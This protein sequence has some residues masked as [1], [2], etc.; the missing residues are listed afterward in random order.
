MSLPRGEI[1]L[2]ITVILM[3]LLI[4]SNYVVTENQ[5]TTSKLTINKLQVQLNEYENNMNLKY[6]TLNNR[7]KILENNNKVNKMTLIQLNNSTKLNTKRI[8]D[9]KNATDVTSLAI[10]RL[11]NHTTNA[12]L[13]DDINK[14]RKHINTKLDTSIDYVDYSISNM[15]HNLTQQMYSTKIE[16]DHSI[17]RVNHIA[18]DAEQQLMVM[19]DKVT[20]QVY[21]VSHALNDTLNNVDV[22]VAT[23]S[24]EINKE[25]ENIQSDISA[26]VAFADKQFAAENDFVKYQLAGTFTLIACL[27]S[28][29]HMT[30]HQKHFVKP[31][32]QRRIMAILWMVP[33]YSLTSWLS[34]VFGPSGEVFFNAIRDIYEAYVVYTF[35]GLLIAVLEEGKGLS[36]LIERV[37]LH[38][39]DEQR[40][41]VQAQRLG[42]PIPIEHIKPPF[43]CCY[44]Y[45][46]PI[47]IAITWLYQCK[48]MVMQF[49]LLK[50]LLTIMPVI[51]LLFGV[52]YYHIDVLLEA[53][54]DLTLFQ[55][56]NFS[57]PQLYLLMI[58]NI[59]VTLAFYGLL[60]FYHGTEK[61]LA[62]CEPWPKFVCVKS[63]VFMTFW[64][65]I[66]ISAMSSLGMV[67]ERAA[68][69]IQNLLICIEMLV[70]SLAHVYVF[71][72]KEWEEG[73][74]K[75]KQI[76]LRD[77]LAFRDFMKDVKQMV[78]RWSTGEGLGGS[79]GGGRGSYEGSEASSP[80]KRRQSSIGTF[81]MNMADVDGNVDRRTTGSGNGGGGIAMQYR[82]PSRLS[83]QNTHNLEE[84]NV[85]SSGMGM[86]RETEETPLL[87]S[88]NNNTNNNG[89][90]SVSNNGSLSASPFVSFLQDN[91]HPNSHSNSL[92]HS[93]DGSNNN[94]NSNSDDG[95]HQEL[96]S[97][98][99]LNYQEFETLIQHTKMGQQQQRTSMGVDR[100]MNRGVDGDS[101][102][103]MDRGESYDQDFELDLSGSDGGNDSGGSGSSGGS[104][105]SGVRDNTS[106][107][108]SHTNTGNDTDTD[109]W[110]TRHSIIRHESREPVVVPVR[111]VSEISPVP[112]GNNS[113]NSD[114]SIND[115][116][117]SLELDTNTITISNGNSNNSG[118]S[119]GNSSNNTKKGDD[120]VPFVI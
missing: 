91:S 90:G 39:E 80:I 28:M 16:M 25:V 108:Y 3:V 19:Q 69:Q 21:N 36:H 117:S 14:L 113:H 75:D 106:N 64:Q 27:I 40:S 112:I 10:I 96:G 1:A 77:T 70:A 44:D 52:D 49:V 120:Q 119:T 6:I 23:A 84:G 87:R 45:H 67:N 102:R 63:I 116:D 51:F 71:P 60:S 20:Q 82:N 11:N 107:T 42:K 99:G 41:V 56:I 32:V 18:T 37:T 114:M 105:S 4:F 2:I 7:I 74:K 50:P 48:L 54:D 72:Y 100:G 81:T 35:F 57:S 33:V 26:Y 98:S 58:E 61:E 55:R 94:T 118:N 38:V 104:R 111:G 79:G 103:D 47:R 30:Q 66:C 62:W 29:Y 92:M 89:S 68:G 43:P 9:I 34:L 46:I 93:V 13:K 8:F 73:Y 110:S 76:M 17:D 115:L 31:N 53:T 15:E 109:P 85:M 65:G 95:S 97:G 88:G 5:I 22:V 78:T 83:Y 86:D 101:D 59:S 24:I 12:D